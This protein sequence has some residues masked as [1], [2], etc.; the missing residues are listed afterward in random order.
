MGA[1][2]PGGDDDAGGGR[3]RAPRRACRSAGPKRAE[4]ARAALRLGHGGRP[5][6]GRGTARPV[7]YALGVASRSARKRAAYSFTWPLAR[8][9]TIASSAFRASFFLPRP[10]SI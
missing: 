8:F 4:S 3:A 10:A 6:R 7:A 2:R 9:G 1:R 5:D